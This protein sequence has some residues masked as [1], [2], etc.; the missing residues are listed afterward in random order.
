LLDYD[1]A[2]SI[3]TRYVSRLAASD[4]PRNHELADALEAVLSEAAHARRLKEALL[5]LRSEFTEAGRRLG[6]A[7][8]PLTPPSGSA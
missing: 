6:T 2:A 8:P 3:V 7:E 1:R 5:L 4:E